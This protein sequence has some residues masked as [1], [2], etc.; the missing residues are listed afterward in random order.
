[1]V[2][3]QANRY[4][5]LCYDDGAYMMCSTDGANCPPIEELENV[6]CSEYL[7]AND[8]EVAVGGA[9]MWDYR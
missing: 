5:R 4:S 9:L 1:V 6:H 8:H 7:R 3:V 2:E